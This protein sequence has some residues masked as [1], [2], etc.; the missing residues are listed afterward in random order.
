MC[1]ARRAALAVAAG[2]LLGAPRASLERL[3]ALGAAYGVAGVLRSVTALAR[4][5][6][7]LL[8]EDVLAA[9]RACRWRR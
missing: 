6:R 1:S 2:R 3:R 8:P 5:G 4:Q 7:C 9:A